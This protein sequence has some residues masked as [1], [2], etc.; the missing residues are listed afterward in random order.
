MSIANI[1]EN[2]VRLLTPQGLSGGLEISDAA[3]RFLS[4]K[5]GF[6]NFAYRLPPGIIAGGR[7]KDRANA[8]AVLTALKDQV[9]PQKKKKIRVVVSVPADNIFVQ[10][11]QLPI[12][13][14]ENLA[15]AAEFNLKM[16]SPMGKEGA[17]S[18]WQ[19]V[20]ETYDQLELLAAFA[21]SAVIDG[22]IDVLRT[23]GFNVI[24]IEFPALSIIR[25]IRESGVSVDIK[26]P[27]ILLNIASEG[28]DFMVMRNGNPYFDYFHPWGLTQGGARQISWSDFEDTVIHE[29]K[30][31]L[32]FYNSHW[33]KIENLILIAPAFQDR[34]SDLI[35][36]TFSLKVQPLALRNYGSLPST[37]FVAL[38]SAFRSVMPRSRDSFIS[39]MSTGVRQEYFREEL[40]IL[41]GFWRNIVMTALVFGIIS[42]IFVLGIIN[43]ISASLQGQMK[44]F[45]VTTADVAELQKLQDQAKTFNRLVDL[46][47]RAEASKIDWALFFRALAKLAGPRVSIDRITVSSLSSPVFISGTALNETEVFAF[48][49]RLEDQKGFDEVTLPLTSIRQSVGGRTGFEL[50]FRLLPLFF[51][52]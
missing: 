22:Y 5:K 14:K 23:A 13:A 44:G 27:Y 50:N 10:T 15:D 16:L 32:N 36:K 6:K 43:R 26:T 45:A 40:L 41:T 37:W 7:I 4:I 2:F 48:Q 49:K 3:V 47:A 24:A 39:L 11:F 46:T 42:F 20:G 8:I 31:I 17:F 51:Q 52:S 34:L 29:V 33:G 1:I 30:R 12:A 18:D 19:V 25:L 9:E 35:T 28:L 38:G 21:P